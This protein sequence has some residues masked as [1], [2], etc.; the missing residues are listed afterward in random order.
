MQ[1][2]KYQGKISWFWRWFLNNQMTAV[3]LNILLFLLV[4]FTFTKVSYLF[5]PV[6]Q[7]LAVVG[8]PIIM[9]GIL[10]YLM[11][12]LVDLLENKGVKRVYSI[13]G[14]FIVVVA[15]I[16]WGIVVIIP[17]IQSQTMSFINHLPGYIETIQKEGMKFFNDPTL[18]KLTTEFQD[19]GQ[20]L[21]ENITDLVKN[22]STVTI[23][24]IG[25]FFGT[26]AT[27]VISLIT[28]PF[29]L[30]Y[31]LRD[32]KN[33]GP[34]IVQFLPTKLRQPT[35]KILSEANDQIASY[36]RGQLTVAFAVAVMFVIGFS[37]IGLDYAITLGVIAGFL[38]LIP[39][40]GSFL[41]MV[42]AI[43]LGIVGGP[44][45]LVKVLV[46]FVIEQ[47]IEGRF[48]SPLVLGSQLAVHPI[49]I[50][51][52]LLTSG[53]LFGL[54]GVVLGIPTYAVLKVVISNI[55][56]WYQARSRLYEEIENSQEE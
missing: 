54:V 16:V 15:L 42:P 52:V 11:N 18:N 49:T 30:F 44:L 14:L 36:I 2:S 27:I 35:L 5:E 34:Y 9:A 13:I 25:N 6:W 51:F 26:L 10:Y 38:N 40:L 17:S 7:F 4:V 28:M 24:N 39:Y 29:I 33:L 53:K 12:P 50:L 3:L 41:A 47:T 55:F 32:G 56:Q 48:I 22:L 8:L 43:I 21:L 45:L 23:K 19:S 1:E 20:K 46:V 37:V 31:L